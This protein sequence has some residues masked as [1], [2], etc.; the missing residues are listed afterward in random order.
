MLEALL[1][2]KLSWFVLS[3][4]P[5]D[6]LNAYVFPLAL[7]LARGERLALVLICLGS[8]LVMPQV[9]VVNNVCSVGRYDVV[10]QIETS[11]LQ[12]FLCEQYEALAPKPIEHS[13]T[14]WVKVMTING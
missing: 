12:M 4:G 13:T 2:Y 11:F 6:G 1:S 5:Q 9:R 3:S 8:L 7:L 10:A 14:V